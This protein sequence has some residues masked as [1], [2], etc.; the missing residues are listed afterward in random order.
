MLIVVMLLTTVL[1]RVAIVAT[2]VYVILPKGF[3]CPRCS[4]RLSQ[5]WHPVLRRLL[6]RIEHRWCMR[7]GWNGLVSSSVARNQA[8]RALVEKVV[9]RPVDQDK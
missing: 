1:L 6:P 7:C 9:P 5:I 8:R 4:C 3:S 2:V